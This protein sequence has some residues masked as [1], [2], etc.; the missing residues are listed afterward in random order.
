MPTKVELCLFDEPGTREIERVPLPEYTDEVWHGYL[1]DARPGTALRLPCPRPLRAGGRP[2]L[3]S[4]QAAARPLRQGAVRTPPLVATP[5][6]A[7]ASARPREDLSF[8]RRDNARRHAEM[9]GGRS[10]P[11]PGAT[12]ARRAFPWSDTVIYEAHV[13]GFTMRIPDVPPQLARHL[14]RSGAPGGHRHSCSGSASR[15]SSCCRSTPSSMT[16]IWSSG[17]CAI[18]GAITR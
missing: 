1:P 6:S 15:R 2:P 18:T 9:P 5:I 10:A 12:T 4:Q 17:G 3:Q 14:R 11:S 13:R 8:D 16:A 7:T